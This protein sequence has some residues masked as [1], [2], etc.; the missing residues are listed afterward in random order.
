MYIYV[1]MPVIVGPFFDENEMLSLGN[2]G[3]FSGHMGLFCGRYGAL[4]QEK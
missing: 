1:H 2:K 3:L 4:L